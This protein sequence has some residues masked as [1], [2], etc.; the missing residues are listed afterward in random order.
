[1]AP[2]ARNR[3][4]GLLLAGGLSRRMGGGDKCLARVAGR[5][6]LAHVIARLEPQVARLVLNANGDPGRF[7]G[8][9]LPVVADPVEGFAG[10][11]AGVLAGMLWAREHAPEMNWVASAATD[12][13]FFPKDLVARLH[14][15]IGG[16]PKAIALAA[17]N[18]RLHPVFGLWP[19]ALADDLTGA[20]REGVRKVMVWVE[21]HFH[22][23]H[24]FGR[25][26]PDRDPF[27]NAN[28]PEELAKVESLIREDAL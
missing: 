16:D 1:M 17:S 24:D 5:P 19:V 20:L 3:A 10:P 22:A 21:R 6:M 15:A 14:A 4:L 7:D 25:F 26:D 18:G 11:L 28:T 13:P 12:T 27:F 23:V 8:F 2:D 9:G